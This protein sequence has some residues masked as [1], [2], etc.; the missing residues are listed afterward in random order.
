MTEIGDAHASPFPCDT[1]LE[2][3][4]QAHQGALLCH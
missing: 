1:L 4:H 3:W 2:N